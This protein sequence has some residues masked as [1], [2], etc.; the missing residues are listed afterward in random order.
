MMTMKVVVIQ[1]ISFRSE[2]TFPVISPKAN[3]R[4][5]LSYKNTVFVIMMRIM[6]MMTMMM[7]ILIT[8]RT[9]IL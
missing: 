4:L 9:K 2:V 6:M 1:F 3:C 5:Y 7:I 8:I